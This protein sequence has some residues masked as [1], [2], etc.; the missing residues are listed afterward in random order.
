MQP[1]EYWHRKFRASDEKRLA[2][3]NGAPPCFFLAWPSPKPIPIAS[4]TYRPLSSQN[5]SN[6]TIQAY[7]PS[8][9]TA[10]CHP[11]AAGLLTRQECQARVHFF[12]FPARTIPAAR[13][14]SAYAYNSLYPST[15]PLNAPEQVLIPYASGPY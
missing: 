12:P 6:T 9:N 3:E 15:S 11:R 2:E 10:R 13:P 5:S 4:A 8:Q 14:R 1:A 7:P